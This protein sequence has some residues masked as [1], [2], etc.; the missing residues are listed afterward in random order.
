MTPP[1]SPEVGIDA[2][3]IAD[4]IATVR[5]SVRLRDGYY[6]SEELVDLYLVGVLRGVAVGLLD[7]DGPHRRDQA[8]RGDR[9]DE[10]ARSSA[11]LLGQLQRL[12]PTPA[13]VNPEPAGIGPTT[14]VNPEPKRRDSWAS[15]G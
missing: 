9:L 10:L 11:E 14:E 5:A 4:L 15:T 1:N 2:Q 7:A 12:R 3:S 13:E 8:A 6:L